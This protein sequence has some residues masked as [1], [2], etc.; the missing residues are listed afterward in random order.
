V[1]PQIFTQPLSVLFINDNNFMQRLPD[2]LGNTPV[3]YLTFANNR[4]TGRIPRSIGN[5][6]ATL[7]EVLFLN[8]RLSGCIPY[9]VGL[10]QNATVFD[11]GN[12]FLTG[13]LPWSLGCL[14]KIEQLNFAGNFLYGQVPE[15]VCELENL[16]NLSL[17]DNYFTIIGPRCRKLIKSGVVDVRQNCIRGLPDQRPPWECWWF[18]ISSYLHCE[19]PWWFTTYVPC[20]DPPEWHDWHHRDHRDHRHHHYPPKGSKR[21]LLS[22][23]ALSR[24]RL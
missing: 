24:N 1:P 9:E 15:L 14:E 22:Y 18:F 13:P 7:I 20:R 4:F 23:A 19:Y 3:L 11:V 16:E 5:A 6:S 2:N 12:N 17:S 8:N 21:K 10:L